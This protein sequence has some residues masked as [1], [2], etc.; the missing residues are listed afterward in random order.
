MVIYAPTL[1]Q[2]LKTQTGLPV[3]AEPLGTR[4]DTPC[5]TYFEVSN[6]DR[7]EGDNL[8]YSDLAFQVKVWGKTLAET[9]EWAVKVDKI[10]KSLGFR[11]T[12]S[13]DTREEELQSKILRY[14][15]IAFERR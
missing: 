4:R 7:L 3:Y 6:I 10:M 11:R 1:V 2:E 8:G 9:S 12:F 5:L 13:L 14:N 15:A